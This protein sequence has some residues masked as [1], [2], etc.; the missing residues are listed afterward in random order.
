MRLRYGSWKKIYDYKKGDIVPVIG[1]EIKLILQKSE[2]VL[3]YWNTQGTISFIYEDTKIKTHTQSKVTKKFQS[4]YHSI[5]EDLPENIAK[6][7]K[8]ELGYA[9]F[10]A[11]SAKR[12][13]QALKY[14]NLIERRISSDANKMYFF[15]WSVIYS[16]II[17]AL[18]TITYFCLKIWDIEHYIWLTS[19]GGCIGALF[20]LIQRN[21]NIKLY[22]FTSELNLHILVLIRCLVGTLSGLILYF[23]SAANLAFGFAQNNIETLMSFSL[24]SG[25]SERFIPQILYKMETTN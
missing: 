13:R 9:L 23:V 25:F 3:V 12:D 19:A 1:T 10:H 11:L 24:L 16:I 5:S 20:S 17:S 22:P 18:L 21:K 7:L 6:H 15:L 4:L 14:F 2:E 8:T